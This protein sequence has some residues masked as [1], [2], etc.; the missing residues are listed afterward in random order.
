MYNPKE[1][2][3]CKRGQVSALIATAQQHHSSNILIDQKILPLDKLISQ[4][5]CVLTFNLINGTYLL[6]DFFNHGD[7][8]HHYFNGDLRIPLY[9]TTHSQVF[10][11]Y[12]AINTWTGLSG[13][14]R[15]S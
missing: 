7:V 14:L 4:Q 6:N 8:W 9:A 2:S 10:V 13:D 12:S 15:S 1:V 5:V 11:R 3:A